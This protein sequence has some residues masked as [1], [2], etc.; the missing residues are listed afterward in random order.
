[1]SAHPNAT[2]PTT[3][4]D[5]PLP[6]PSTTPPQRDPPSTL[7]AAV[8]SS[9][10]PSTYLVPLPL[11]TCPSS[12]SS[13][14]VPPLSFALVAPGVYRSACPSAR[15][16]PFLRGLGLKAVVYLCADAYPRGNLDHFAS[17]GLEVKVFP[18]L[19]NTEPFQSSD[20][21]TL[22]A[23]LA[24]TLDSRH[25]PV[26]VH[27]NKGKHRTGSLFAMSIPACC[28]QRA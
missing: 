12:F 22:E 14:L 4:N 5:A 23:A 25:Q 1:M 10:T 16:Y 21:G 6:T 3:P 11:S 2:I 18:L 15:N 27:C 17:E 20:H 8:A 9:I 19:G 13:L 28:C 26:L 7:P 24:Y